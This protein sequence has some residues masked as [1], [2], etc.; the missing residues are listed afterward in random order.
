M[1]KEKQHFVPKSYL[2]N[3]CVDETDHFYASRNIRRQNKWGKPRNRH[4]SSV[5]YSLDIY[6]VNS[7]FA[8]RFD[9]PENYVEKNAFWYEGDFLKKLLL[10][11]D[12]QGL[13]IGILQNFPISI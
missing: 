13:E 12:A 6:D 8:Q 7:Q 11:I 9:I 2:K 5:C 3:F 10:Q 1:K 4:I